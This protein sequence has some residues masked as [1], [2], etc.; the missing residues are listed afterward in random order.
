MYSS[1]L[2]L[3]CC[4]TLGSGAQ[5]QNHRARRHWGQRVL[6]AGMLAFSSLHAVGEV[7]STQRRQRVAQALAEELAV[8]RFRTGWSSSTP[9]RITDE[10]GSADPCS[11]WRPRQGQGVPRPKPAVLNFGAGGTGFPAK[12]LRTGAADREIILQHRGTAIFRY[13]A[14]TSMKKV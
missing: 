13:A 5:A 6:L 2:T 12:L 10:Q 7:R 3:P 11:A 14:G 9:G 1:G 4:S 8:A